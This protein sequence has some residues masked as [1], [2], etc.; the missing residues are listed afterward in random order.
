MEDML[1]KR[2]QLLY[3][4]VVPREQ[5]HRVMKLALGMLVMNVT[6]SAAP[7]VC[8]KQYFS[9]LSMEIGAKST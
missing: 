1:G 5:E 7:L 6:F 2:T 3:W 4:N 8:F 9:M